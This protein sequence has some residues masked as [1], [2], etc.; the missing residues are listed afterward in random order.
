MCGRITQNL[1]SDEIA[2]LFGA[3]DEAHT[4]G[5]RLPKVMSRGVWPSVA[6]VLG[7][8]LQLT[9]CMACGLH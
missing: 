1:T 4:P 6:A 2:E 5:G 7:L 3:D 9:K 8:A